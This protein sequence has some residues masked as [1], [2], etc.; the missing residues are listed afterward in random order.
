MKSKPIQLSFHGKPVVG[1]CDLTG[2]KSLILIEHLLRES[3]DGVVLS[4][5]DISDTLSIGNRTVR[6]YT[7][8]LRKKGLCLLMGYRNLYG[9]PNTIKELEKI[10]GDE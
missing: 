6:E 8:V 1:V 4:S 3:H 5:G 2:K 9:S 10:Q 7:A